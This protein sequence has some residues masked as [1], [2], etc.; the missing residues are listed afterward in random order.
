MKVIVQDSHTGSYLSD[1][2]A[3]V[4]TRAEARDFLTLLRAY[5]F[6]QKNTSVQFKVLLHCPED[7]YC[8]TIIDGIGLADSHTE[9]TSAVVQVQPH[10]VKPFL[11]R[12][13]AIANPRGIRPQALAHRFNWT[14]N[15]F[16]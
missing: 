14:G 2:G 3:W 1:N 5:T 10:Q 12:R 8:T 11:P 4:A 7:K 16:N 9:S 13:L 6:A 15:P